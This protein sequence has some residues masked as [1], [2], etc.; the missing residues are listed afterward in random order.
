MF[1]SVVLSVSLDVIMFHHEV[2]KAGNGAWE[3]NRKK[4]EVHPDG[5][6]QDGTHTTEEKYYAEWGASCL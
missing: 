3:M 4:R 1:Q 5:D 2:G 6:T